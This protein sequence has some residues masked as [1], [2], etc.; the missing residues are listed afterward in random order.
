MQTRRNESMENKS[1]WHSRS[2]S[3]RKDQAT[4]LKVMSKLTGKSINS[5]LVDI[6]RKY[7]EEEG[8]AENQ[9]L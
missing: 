1:E 2:F 5:C 3:I 9:D 4:A 8:N 6:L 7:R